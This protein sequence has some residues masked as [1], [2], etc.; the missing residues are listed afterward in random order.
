MNKITVKIFTAIIIIASLNVLSLAQTRIRFA[1]D[2]SAAT[3]QGTIGAN[4]VREFWIN[5]RRG[6]TMTVQ[7]TSG[8]NKIDLGLSGPNGHIE[9]G[10]N[11]FSQ[12]EIYDSGNHTIA[13]KNSGRSATRYALT[14]TVR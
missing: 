10:D 9:F 6:Q 13:I 3:L 1:K 11:G 12:I 2:R 7:V 5:V 14:V 8:N 4:A